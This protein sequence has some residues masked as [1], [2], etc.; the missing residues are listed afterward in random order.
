MRVRGWGTHEFPQL[1]PRQTPSWRA[2][3]GFPFDM[4]LPWVFLLSTRFEFAP[5][6]PV[7]RR[8]T[9]RNLG[10]EDSLSEEESRKNCPV[11]SMNAS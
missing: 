5:F 3:L 9:R 11:K 10:M 4:A 7:V 2:P 6:G 1:W 8:E